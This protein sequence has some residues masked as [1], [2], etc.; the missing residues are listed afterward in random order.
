MRL[1]IKLWIDWIKRLLASRRRQ[2]R[3]L[4][5]SFPGEIRGRWMNAEA[6][7]TLAAGNG[8]CKT[9]E[10][11]GPP[12]CG[13]QKHDGVDP[14]EAEDAARE[15]VAKRGAVAKELGANAGVAATRIG[16]DDF[17][18]E[19][20]RPRASRPRHGHRAIGHDGMPKTLRAARGMVEPTQLV[21]SGGNGA[22]IGGFGSDGNIGEDQVVAHGLESVA[23]LG[24][25]VRDV[26]DV[27]AQVVGHDFC[28]TKG[29]AVER[30]AGP[31]VADARHLRRQKQ[32]V[33][34]SR[35]P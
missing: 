19:R 17:E 7:Q 12:P 28:P 33:Q 11:F 25:R 4:R 14:R 31:G 8:P 21:L 29:K 20:L 18:K 23:V 2:H 27:Q 34:V 13:R 6:E 3:H 1:W 9:R 30:S 10:V 26:G 5:L 16:T 35:G 24:R 15:A 32:P 22:R